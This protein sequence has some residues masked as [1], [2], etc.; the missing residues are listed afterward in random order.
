M[1]E[2]KS[3]DMIIHSLENRAYLP[4][5]V[6]YVELY[7]PSKREK[8]ASFEFLQNCPIKESNLTHENKKIILKILS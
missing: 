2:T 4:D 5:S 6:V 7:N 1:T 8:L 3:S